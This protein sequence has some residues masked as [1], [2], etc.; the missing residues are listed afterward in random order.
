LKVRARLHHPIVFQR[1]E[2]VGLVDA[3]AVILIAWS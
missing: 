3:H 1:T 2:M